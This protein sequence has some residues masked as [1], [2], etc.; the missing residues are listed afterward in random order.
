[1]SN[2]RARRKREQRRQERKRLAHKE[3]TPA[4]SAEELEDFTDFTVNYIRMVAAGKGER[5]TRVTPKGFDR[6]FP[7]LT[8]DQEEAMNDLASDAKARGIPWKDDH[9]RVMSAII[10]LKG[11]D[12]IPPPFTCHFLSCIL[13]LP[14]TRINEIIRDFKP[15]GLFA[16][17][18][19]TYI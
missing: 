10:R 11:D 13:E 15:L 3:P 5:G 16:P 8:A 7:Q 9:R 6:F 14:E 18:E 1:M 17:P 2:D 4:M 19:P 12:D